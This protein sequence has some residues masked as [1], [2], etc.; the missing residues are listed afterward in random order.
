M[1]FGGLL[2]ALIIL[3]ALVGGVYWSN[4]AKEA[5]DKAPPKDAAPKVLTI[6]EADFKTIRLQKTAGDT[7]IIQKSDAGTT[8]VTIGPGQIPEAS[9]SAINVFA[10]SRCVSFIKKIAERK[11]IQNF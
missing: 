10:V 1:K 7:T 2:T 3:A 4:K 8:S 5:A 9:I 11:G 6:P